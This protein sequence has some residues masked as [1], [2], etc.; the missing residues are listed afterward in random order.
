[1]LYPKYNS[2]NGSWSWRSTRTGFRMGTNSFL[3]FLMYPFTRKAWRARFYGRSINI[4]FVVLLLVSTAF[5]EK[6]TATI[7]GPTEVHSGALVTLDASGSAGAETWGWLVDTSRVNVPGT[8]TPDVS[9]QVEQLQSLGFTVEGPETNDVP[10]YEIEDGG[11]R[12][13][14]SS[15]PGVYRL[16]LGASNAD[17]VAMLEWTVTVKGG[18]APKP[19]PK[20]DPKPEPIVEPVIPAGK[21]G[22]GIKSWRAAQLVVT[23]NRPAEAKTLA[24]ALLLSIV[25][26]DGQAMIDQF[27][28]TM[29]T[30]F[31]AAQK[32]A[33]EPWRAAY[34]TELQALQGANKLNAKE[35]FVAAFSEMALGLSAVEK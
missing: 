14:L 6:P 10:L 35:D 3:R 15:Y 32:T 34:L 29:K 31:S 33:W 8:A 17:G 4:P 28:S 26:S 16:T 5:A 7:D 23:Q 20:P 25:A 12:I 22:L 27:A 21:F 9:R 30:Q 18:V 1:V 13:R 11:K 24:A 19:D 2:I